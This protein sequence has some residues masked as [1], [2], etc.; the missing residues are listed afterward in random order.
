MSKHLRKNLIHHRDLCIYPYHKVCKSPFYP[1]PWH[2]MRGNLLHL[3]MC[4]FNKDIEL[5]QALTWVRAYENYVNVVSTNHGFYGGSFAWSPKH[6][7]EKE[8]AS[9]KGKNMFLSADI[10]L[11]VKDL[12]HHQI[13]GVNNAIKNE[14]AK[15]RSTCRDDNNYKAPPPDYPGRRNMDQE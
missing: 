7:T 1:T 4:A 12:Y 14:A 10:V 9:L 15:W 6:G 13:Y 8:I 3:F 2:S 11:P 5:F